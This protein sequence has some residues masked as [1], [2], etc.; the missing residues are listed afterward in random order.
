MRG[1]GFKFDGP[2]L[3]RSAG[4]LSRA[5]SLEIP[6]K[7][8]ASGF[9]RQAAIANVG[10]AVAVGVGAVGVG[11]PRE[12]GSKAVGR[13]EPGAFADKHQAKA[14]PEMETDGIANGHPALLHQ[15]EWGDSPPCTQK[16]RQK[17]RK[18]GNGITL[19][20]QSRET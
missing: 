11:M 9:G 3:K 8:G 19:D 13:G 18:Q 2:L 17:V 4:D 10:E 1:S 20:S 6:Q 14:G 12:I 15:S 5:G 7:A 16:L